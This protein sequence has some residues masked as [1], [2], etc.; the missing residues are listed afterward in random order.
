[1]TLPQIQWCHNNLS[2]KV[3][4]PRVFVGPSSV[5][6]SYLQAKKPGLWTR[7]LQK[8]MTLPKMKC[9]GSIWDG[10]RYFQI[11]KH[12][13][14]EECHSCHMLDLPPKSAILKPTY[15]KISDFKHFRYMFQILKHTFRFWEI[16]L[17]D[18]SEIFWHT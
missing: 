9:P 11:L 6:S 10:G 13:A 4:I 3:F 14:I 17:G 15:R 12:T 2:R 8:G 1:M 7:L 5:S 18:V 16:L